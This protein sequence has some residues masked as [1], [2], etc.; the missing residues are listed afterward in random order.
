MLHAA[1]AL[2]SAWLQEVEQRASMWFRGHMVSFVFIHW[3]TANILHRSKQRLDTVG[4]I[5][6]WNFID[7]L[8]W[9]KAGKV[10]CCF[11]QRV[12]RSV[13]LSFFVSPPP[14]DCVGISGSC[15][16]RLSHLLPVFWG[17]G[18]KTVSQPPRPLHSTQTSVTWERM[19]QQA[20]CS[21]HVASVLKLSSSETAGCCL[22]PLIL[23][24]L[25][26]TAEEREEEGEWESE[27][28]FWF[29]IMTNGGWH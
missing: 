19:Q 2:Q 14:G 6:W 25:S 1:F 26:V 27:K 9:A 13:F 28:N 18:S 3:D 5:I 16:H 21:W 29:S 22:L 7:F 20:L 23:R 4:G 10:I 8:Q 12:Q 24:P 15:A 11:M 17:S